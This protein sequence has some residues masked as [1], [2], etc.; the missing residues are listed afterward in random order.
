[1][2]TGLPAEKPIA[3][4]DN[5]RRTFPCEACGADLTFSIGVQNLRCDYCGT[6]REIVNAHGNRIVDHDYHLMLAEL[7]NRKRSQ[8]TTLSSGESFEIS[9][10][11]CAAVVVFEG[12]L[13]ASE[14]AFCGSPLV[15]ESV[16]QAGERIGVDGVVPFGIPEETAQKAL[17]EWVRGLWFAPGPF[18]EYGIRGRLQGVYLPYWTFDAMTYSEYRGQRGEH[19]WVSVGSGKSRRRVR[20]TRWYSAQGSFE[21]FFDEVLAP[22]LRNLPKPLIQA[23]EPWPVHKAEPFNAEY[24]SGFS[25]RTY[26]IDLPEGFDLAEERMNQALRQEACRL[27]G[28]DTQRLQTLN[29]QF[30]GLTFKHLLLPVWLLTYRYGNKPY[31]VVINAGTGE[32]AGE[33]PWSAWKI[34]FTVLAVLLMLLILFSLGQT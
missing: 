18:K 32:V 31:R 33:R 16:H 29:T 3:R 14:C 34:G 2:P 5:Q 8:V 1:M 13:T 28:G 30:E 19:Y 12:T 4:A 23:L 26:D 15:R 27:I 20:R 7:E 22:A 11:T 21:R 9:C 17:R 10:K 6:V 25:A 24:L